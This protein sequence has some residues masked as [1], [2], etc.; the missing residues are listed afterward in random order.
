M[1]GH[2]SAPG[3]EMPEQGFGM[4][5]KAHVHWGNKTDLDKSVEPAYTEVGVHGATQCHCALMQQLEN[6]VNAHSHSF[7]AI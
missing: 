7:S 4:Q 1:T 2:G 6:V 3:E 5:A